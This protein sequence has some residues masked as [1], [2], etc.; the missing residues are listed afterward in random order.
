L[1]FDLNEKRYVKETGLEQRIAAIIEP[2][3]NDLGYSPSA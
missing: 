3:A 2:V 1:A